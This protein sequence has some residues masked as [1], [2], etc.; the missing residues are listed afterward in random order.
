[1]P[2]R[3]KKLD[4]L[5]EAYVDGRISKE[6]YERNADALGEPATRDGQDQNRRSLPMKDRI[7]RRWMMV[8]VVTSVVVSSLTGTVIYILSSGTLTGGGLSGFELRITPGSLAVAPGGTAT[9]SVSLTGA[10][11]YE[12]MISLSATGAPEESFLSF[13]PSSVTLTAHNVSTLRVETSSS[14]PDGTYAL[15]VTATDGILVRTES[16]HLEVT[17]QPVFTISASPLSRT[18]TPGEEATFMV[19]ATSLNGYQGVVSLSASS[20]VP[21]GTSASLV[22][23]TVRPTSSSTL[24]IVETS[25]VADG[26]YTISIAG[27]D[28]VLMHSTT[29]DLIVSRTGTG[30]EWIRGVLVFDPTGMSYVRGRGTRGGTTTA[31]LT[32]VEM[33]GGIPTLGQ[34][35]PVQVSDMQ[36]LAVTGDFLL[37]DT[38]QGATVS[39]SSFTIE[40]VTSNVLATEIEEHNFRNV[41]LDLLSVGVPYGNYTY[42]IGLGDAAD[43]VYVGLPLVPTFFTPSRVVGT[44]LPWDFVATTGFL[45]MD[46]SADLEEIRADLGLTLPSSFPSFVL[47]HEIRFASPTNVRGDAL[48]IVR[49]EEVAQ[50]LVDLAGEEIDNET[51]TRMLD[52]SRNIRMNL[53]TLGEEDDTVQALDRWLVFAHQNVTREELTG[54]VTLR[55]AES[56]LAMAAAR[57][58]VSFNATN[59]ENVALRI[60]VAVADEDA[61]VANSSYLRREVR[62]FW[63]L[64]AQ[65]HTTTMVA[66]ASATG[67]VLALDAESFSEY[68]GNALGLDTSSMTALRALYRFRNPAF[69]LLVDRQFPDAFVGTGAKL[70]DYSSLVYVPDFVIGADFFYYMEARGVLYDTWRFLNINP[71]ALNSIP[72]LVADGVEN[73]T[74][75]MIS[76]SLEGLAARTDLGDVSLIETSGYIVGST[77]KTV[78]EYT[79]FRDV[80]RYIPIDVG[81][82]DI[83]NESGGIRYHVPVVYLVWDKGPTFVAEHVRVR[84]LYVRDNVLRD[85]V[86]SFGTGLLDDGFLVDLLRELVDN[87]V[88]NTG[89]I[90]MLDGF[91]LAYSVVRVPIPENLR[92]EQLTAENRMTDES[93][94]VEARVVAYVQ[95]DGAFSPTSV[96][97]RFVVTSPDGSVYV[98]NRLGVTIAIGETRPFEPLPSIQ[99]TDPIPGIYRAE[100]YLTRFLEFGTTYDYRATTFLL[101][102]DADPPGPFR[103]YAPSFPL[104]FEDTETTLTWTAA[105]DSFL[106][107]Y[108]VHVSTTP[109]FVPGPSTLRPPATTL[110]SALVTGLTPNVWYYYRVR[111]FDT[112]GRFTDSNEA[113]SSYRTAD[114]GSYGSPLATRSMTAWSEELSCGSV[115]CS[116]GDDGFRIGLTAGQT[117]YLNL[118]VPILANFDLYLYDS[119]GALVDSSTAIG[120]LNEFIAFTVATAGDY[121]IVAKSSARIG[122]NS[123]RYSLYVETT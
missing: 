85:R 99:I 54:R 71:P 30:P 116:D 110:T 26:T 93:Q 76:D 13:T 82:Y 74:T 109:G 98:G 61:V 77:V 79:P 88:Q 118:T 108:E 67:F 38:P 86:A 101:T 34:P 119:G 14:A 107:Y 83:S 20:G 63:D 1:M 16:A 36:P 94:P 27:T 24:R 3:Q 12:G 10:G 45:Q 43:Y 55:V 44:V 7:R 19:S 113:S 115:S 121:Y 122:G 5:L 106:D 52:I 4:R 92:I 64:L 72:L 18:I 2:D 96:R 60:H 33:V 120:G 66:S 105:S 9:F 112:G 104:L 32:S 87:I 84:A 31:Y 56:D 21:A 62:E 59:R 40:S 46:L 23:S 102:L 29:V 57:L 97:V 49:P 68:L 28:G 95:R 78:L 17:R 117:L 22:P 103:L 81:V 41:E 6:I 80:V 15:I 90:E 50:L 47:V 69:G 11:G 51:A 8:L 25:N 123:G 53:I 100:A 42:G 73:S 48:D 37:A 58:G 111:A 39:S 35:V 91:L 114:S 89:S 75:G 65:P 70:W